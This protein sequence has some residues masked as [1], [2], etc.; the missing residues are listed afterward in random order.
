MGIASH[1]IPA[2]WFVQA[3]QIEKESLLQQTPAVYSREDS[4]YLISQHI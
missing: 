3:P 4:I 2:D 1:Q